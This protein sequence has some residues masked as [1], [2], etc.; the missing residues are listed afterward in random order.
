LRTNSSWQ[1]GAAAP[2]QVGLPLSNE[3]DSV[4]LWRRLTVHDDVVAQVDATPP[5]LSKDCH[6]AE[7]RRIAIC[8]RGTAQVG[9]MLSN[10]KD[11]ALLVVSIDGMQRRRRSG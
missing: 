4:L 6:S 3:K 8:S 11:L 7:Q 1:Q 5:M 9:V 10:A 2:P